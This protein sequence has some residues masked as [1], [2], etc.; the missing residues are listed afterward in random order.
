ME[1]GK[2]GYNPLNPEEDRHTV[3]IS[4]QEKYFSDVLGKERMERLGD[5]PF[6]FNGL[7]L[8]RQEYFSLH[9]A[10]T[11]ARPIQKFLLDRIL[12]LKSIADR[13]P[14]G[15]CIFD[16]DFS[17]EYQSRVLVAKDRAASFQHVIKDYIKR[18][19]QKPKVLIFLVEHQNRRFIAVV[20]RLWIEET[21]YT[22]EIKNFKDSPNMLILD[23]FMVCTQ[24]SES[25]VCKY[26]YVNI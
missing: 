9:P 16:F 6:S 5:G 17:L 25:L 22:E 3:S 4:E 21:E 14:R 13:F 2:K 1:N 8:T 15:L 10:C 7:S 12:N 23:P 26:V 11:M 19:R 24:E 18:L 20:S